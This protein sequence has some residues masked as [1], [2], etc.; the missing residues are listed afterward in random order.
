[1]SCCVIQ[2]IVWYN[3]FVGSCPSLT[4]NSFPQFP[5]ENH[6]PFSHIPNKSLMEFSL[7]LSQICYAVVHIH[8]YLLLTNILGV[9]LPKLCWQIP[10]CFV[11]FFNIIFE[12]ESCAFGLAY[13]SSKS[14]I[15]LMVSYRLFLFFSQVSDSYLCGWYNFWTWWLHSIQTVL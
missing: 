6:I 2:T 15:V 5:S 8:I 10:A 9:L 4:L 12:T 7:N 3:P 14:L 11:F 1:M 13:N